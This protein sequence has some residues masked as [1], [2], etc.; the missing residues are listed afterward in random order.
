M[1]VASR[2]AFFVESSP[3]AQLYT[4]GPVDV[5][6]RHALDLSPVFLGHGERA[7]TID[8]TPNYLPVKAHYGGEIPVDAIF[9]GETGKVRMELVRFNHNAL[10]MLKNRARSMLDQNPVK[11]LFEPGQIGTMIIS[12]YSFFELWLRFTHS[13]KLHN[14]NGD[15][16]DGYRF[17]TAVLEPESIVG[18]SS[19][20]MKVSL[21]FSC[22]RYPFCGYGLATRPG[23]GGFNGVNL[24]LYDHDMSEIGDI[25]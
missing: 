1:R 12:E 22:W 14:N 18:G 3:M 13:K 23:I 6:I 25:D 24:K 11:G 21:T 19:T 9:S 10:N 16:P 7:P 8:I 17:L 2:L 4:T 15:L 5:F 20:I